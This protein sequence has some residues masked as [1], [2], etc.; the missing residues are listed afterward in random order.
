MVEQIQM[1]GQE[2]GLGRQEGRN[3]FQFSV[4][5]VAMLFALHAAVIN[6]TMELYRSAGTARD[7]VRGGLRQIGAKSEGG[8]IGKTPKSIPPAP[9]PAPVVTVIGG[10]GFTAFWFRRFAACVIV[11]SLAIVISF[12]GT[13]VVLKN[14]SQCV[15]RSVP[16]LAA[17]IVS[18]LFLAALS[19]L[20]YI[21]HN[22]ETPDSSR[23]SCRLV[24]DGASN[25][26]GLYNRGHRNRA[27]SQRVP[28]S[29]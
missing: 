19:E 28:P 10:R 7:P 6:G 29:P 21:Q 9:P 16:R 2:G 26:G 11:G 5:D 4:L 15:R 18:L 17:A 8:K 13:A 23:D 27:S 24:G 14:A 22:P 25:C 3:R 12:F 20:T 1:P